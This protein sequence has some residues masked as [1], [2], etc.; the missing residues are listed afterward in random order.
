MDKNDFFAHY[1]IRKEDS[2]KYD[3]GVV[4]FISGS[5]GMAGAA[6]FNLLGARSVGAS[7][8]HS[9][10]PD[11]IYPI[12][13]ANEM[14]AVYH[15]YD[16]ND[17]GLI[18]RA[19]FSK[20]KAVAF[21]SGTDNLP[22]ARKYLEDLIEKCEVPLI[23]DAKGLR[24]LSQAEELYHKADTLILT[25]HMGEFSSLCH[26]DTH[27]I[28]KDRKQIAV[29]FAKKNEVILVLKGPETLV[30]DAK[31]Q[32]Y[33]NHS[34]NCCLARAGSGDV[35]TGMIAGLCSLYDDPYQ[36]VQDAVWL[37]GFLADEAMACH[38]K[39]IFDLSLYPE[40]ADRFFFER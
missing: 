19:S 36:A 14:S 24:L 12:V 26:M 2:N 31:G 28:N 40:L 15:P 17:D 25:P 33:E 34:G 3:N 37:H 27:E 23:V 13:A 35:L 38:S 8:I 16:E 20:I 21:G 1:P 22:H 18:E 4:T 29:N 7:Y 6:L 10:L 5:Y 30:I 9:F 39:E 32:I 11:S